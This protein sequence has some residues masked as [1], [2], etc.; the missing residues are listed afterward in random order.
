MPSQNLAQP[1]ALAEAARNSLHAR[2]PRKKKIRRFF[3]ERKHVHSVAYL[4]RCQGSLEV[5]QI[6]QRG[7]PVGKSLPLYPC[8]ALPSPPNPPRT[9]APEHDPPLSLC[10][11]ACRDRQIDED[12][13][14]SA[15]SWSTQLMRVRTLPNNTQNTSATRPISPTRKPS[16]IERTQAQRNYCY[17]TSTRERQKQKMQQHLEVEVSSPLLRLQKQ[18]TAAQLL[19]LSV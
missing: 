4:F 5:E 7:R 11:A 16:R 8:R 13:K 18:G 3:L 14:M 1:R 2:T 12:K 17:Y 15:T 9:P 10:F 6:Q 19:H